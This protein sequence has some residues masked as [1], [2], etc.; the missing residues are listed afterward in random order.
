M[1]PQSLVRAALR[2]SIKSILWASAAALCL[3]ALYGSAAL[4]AGFIP[5][6]RD[7]KAPPEGVEIFIR[8]N[9][10]HTD[11]VFP[12][13]N[14]QIDWRPLHPA[15]DFGPPLRPLATTLVLAPDL[16]PSRNP[17]ATHIAFGWGDQGFYF[18][19]PYWTDLKP[20][21]ALNA[22]SGR[23]PGAM[24]VE[25]LPRPAPS[26]R[27]R[28]LVITP[29][30]Y[31]ILAAWVQASFTRDA[32]GTLQP[33]PGRGYTAQDTF[34][35]ARDSYSPLLTCNEWTRRGLAAAGVRVPVW[36]PLPWGLMTVS[37]D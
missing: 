8:S 1:Q 31:S 17:R 14:A 30:Q 36:T 13:V 29:Q 26:P 2:V 24:H 33:F 9:G 21:I 22:F 16:D 4:V 27:L 25:Y 7:F 28:R 5:V 23:A 34:Y 11:L 20:G 10:I 6:N 3:A 37:T 18:E 19:T 32:E 12:V 15:R 35:A